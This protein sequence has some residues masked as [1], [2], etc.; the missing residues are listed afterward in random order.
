MSLVL[1]VQD[2]AFRYEEALEPLFTNVSFTLYARDKVA[3][4]G[5]NGA[6]KT[7][8]LKLLSKEL[9]AP[10]GA[11]ICP[12]RVALVRQEDGLTGD[13]TVLD[14][15]LSSNPDLATLHREIQSLECG[16]MAEPLRYA[17]AV[18][19]FAERGGY[20]LVTRLE[21][22]LNALGFA[23]GTLERAAKSLSGG[24]RRL[25]RLMSA[26]LQD[27]GLL[28]FDEPTNY[29]DEAATVFLVEKIQAF[30]GA[31]L[32]VSHDRWFL[33]RTVAKVLELE[34]RQITSYSGNYYIF[35]DTKD[36]LF[37]QKLRQKEQLET[38]I[39]KLQD[40]ERTYKI[41][42][43]R[44]EKEKSGASDKGFIGARAAKLRKRAILAKERR[45]ERI[46]D[47][48]EAKPWVDKQYSVS[49]KE[50]LLSTGTCLVVRELVYGY[51]G[52]QVLGG[53]SLTV[54]W[55]EHV[56]LRGAN[57]SGKST[58]INLLLGELKPDSGTVLWSKGVSIGYLPQ[59]SA[60]NAETPAALFA[61]DEVQ[62]ARTMLGAFRV[63][64]DAFYK[65]LNGLSEG[66]KRKVALVRLIISNPNV[67]VLDEPTTH[68]DYESVEML[69]SA[70]K[71]YSG[72]LL[73]VTH[74]TYLRE[75]I[76]GR[77]LH[78]TSRAVTL[79]TLPEVE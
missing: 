9:A 45:H 27:A 53:V 60:L 65:P 42:G 43:E 58:F 18:A 10:E 24:E 16:G 79:S 13:G 56:A 3:L 14:A 39:S 66:Q 33:D 38:E 67:L 7:T 8:L 49:L 35:C 54:A 20:D 72:T 22:E 75:R 78:F 6:G 61:D 40:I 12:S 68:L 50:P 1:Q 64:G 63:K 77:E 55:G 41:W 2:L 25:L 11:V 15:L 73:L 47:L 57:G 32:V 69:E 59:V 21:A 46:E 70:L 71:D 17:D 30:P 52:K 26:F 62:Q 76:A 36:A 23:A 74:D 34:H 4:L 48:K 31:C 19:D 44:K 5:H 51:R 37:R 29:L 28:I